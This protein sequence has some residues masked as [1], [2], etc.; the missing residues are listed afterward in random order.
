MAFPDIT[1]LSPQDGAV[2]IIGDVKFVYSTA[3]G[4]WEKIDEIATA[5]FV[6]P[7][8]PYNGQLWFDTDTSGRLYIWNE[9]ATS[10]IQL[11]HYRYSMCVGYFTNG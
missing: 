9:A 3:T 8:N 11:P 5:R 7:V 2:H 6:A 10:W 1:T 4:K